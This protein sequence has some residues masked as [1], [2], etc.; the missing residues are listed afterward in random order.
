[1]AFKVAKMKESIMEDQDELNFITCFL[2][3]IITR[4]TPFSLAW[5]KVL[6]SLLKQKV[7]AQELVFRDELL[8]SCMSMSM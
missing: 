5:L 6:K 7:E 4:L 8:V 2:I 3:S 1:M